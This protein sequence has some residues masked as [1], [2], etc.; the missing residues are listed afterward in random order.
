MINPFV[1]YKGLEFFGMYETANGRT[2]AEKDRRDW[3]QISAELIYRFGKT[4][5]F[6]VAGRYNTVSG[7]LVTGQDVEVKRTQLG[8]GWFM[9]KNILTKL[10][11]VNQTYDGFATADVKSEGK[12]HGFSME[13]IVSF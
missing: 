2:Y 5:N 1:K 3:T 7:K 8:L 6:Y 10:E 13:A 9:T 12:F 4:E 11:Y